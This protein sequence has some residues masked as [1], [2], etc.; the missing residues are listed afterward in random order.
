MCGGDSIVVV[1]PMNKTRHRIH[2]KLCG[3]HYFI[4]KYVATRVVSIIKINK[5]VNFVI[6]FFCV[7]IL[8]GFYV[9][10]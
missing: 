9:F 2:N 5:K 10:K 8:H 1:A 4:K 3:Y 6:K 7:L